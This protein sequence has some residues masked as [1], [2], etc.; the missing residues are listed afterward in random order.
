MAT[1]STSGVVNSVQ[2]I[3]GLLGRMDPVIAALP[4]VVGLIE[5]AISS[6][7]NEDKNSVQQAYEKKMAA[8]DAAH[9]E[10]QKELQEEAATVPGSGEAESSPK[11]GGL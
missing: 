7:S 6:F 1:I 10:T 8:T 5:A 9:E 4:E 3:L 11:G 2:T